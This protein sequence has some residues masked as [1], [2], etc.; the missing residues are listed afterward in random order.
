MFIALDHRCI[1][2]RS[3]GVLCHANG[4][5]PHKN[6]RAVIDIFNL[7]KMP[8]PSVGGTCNIREIA[9]ATKNFSIFYVLSGQ[10]FSHSLCRSPSRFFN[11]ERFNSKTGGRSAFI[12]SISN[13]RNV[14]RGPTN[15][16][17][18]R[19]PCAIQ[20]PIQWRL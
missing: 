9:L 11:F 7:V 3:I 18:S 4:L 6:T 5:Y 1:V 10:Y 14:Y 17:K 19:I 15:P 16:P 2:N 20:T 13:H 8:N 12:S